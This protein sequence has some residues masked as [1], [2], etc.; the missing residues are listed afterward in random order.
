MASLNAVDEAID[1]ENKDAVELESEAKFKDLSI[2]EKLAARHVNIKINKDTTIK[3]EIFDR[4]NEIPSDS[5]FN[6]I[7]QAEREGPRLVDSKI[8]DKAASDA[9]LDHFFPSL[10]QR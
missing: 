3:W 1:L 7:L 10:V 6:R 4:N 8:L 9:F 2:E 5:A